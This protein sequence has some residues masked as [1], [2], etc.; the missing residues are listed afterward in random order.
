MGGRESCLVE[1]QA[2]SVASKTELF[3][4][5]KVIS[6]WVKLLKL[7]LIRPKHFNVCCVSA[8]T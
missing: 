8:G 6:T 1:G 2:A 7:L 5:L 4:I 3:L